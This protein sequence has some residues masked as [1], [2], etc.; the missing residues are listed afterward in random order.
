[1]LGTFGLDAWWPAVVALSTGTGLGFLY[2]L[3]PGIGGRIAI[4]LSLPLAALFDPYPAAIFLF[5]LHSVLNT[6]SSIPNIAFGVPTSAADAA[7]I[8]DGY[9]LTKIGRGGEAL[10]ASLSASAIG[11][12]LGALAFLVSIPIAR[13]LVTSFGPPEMLM[14][15]LIGVTLIASL[16]NEGLLQ[17]LVVAALGIIFAMVGLDRMTG[18]FR[19][20]F[21]FLDLW[22]GVSLPAVI[23]G[24]FVIPEMLSTKPQ[25][26]DVAFH[27]AMSTRITDVFRGM[28]VTF[29]YKAVL[30][31]STLYGILIGLTPAVG[32]TVAV[33][34]SYA[35]AARTTRSEIPFGQGAIAGVI[36]P[37]AANNSK[38][39]GAMI[40]TLFFAIPGSSGMAV[41]MAALVFVG[42]T[43]GPNM[44]TTDIGLSFSLAATVLLAN[45]LA[46]P[47]FFMVVPYIVRLSALR[48][49]AIVP[50]AIAISVTAAMI[51]SPT[52]AT[53]VEIFLSAILGVA[54]K[55]ANWPRPPFILG[56]V[57]AQMAERSFFL[58]A[59]LW[60]W[61]ALQR[62]LTLLL[63]ALIVGWLIF[64]L[65]KRPALTLAGS[66]TASIA[67]ATS[68]LIFFVTAFSLSASLSPKTGFA[69]A[70]V[71]ILAV[72]L[73]LIIVL[74][75]V[76]GVEPV[77]GQDK[78]RHVALCALFI[79]L[80]PL[81]GITA[82]TL[83]FVAAVL[84]R[85][86][87]KSR[88]AVTTALVVGVAQMGLLSSVF[89]VLVEKEIIGRALWSALDY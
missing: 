65:R 88:N 33:W 73:C 85:S 22:N 10:G 28:F 69:P 70:A 29:R 51:H 25:G 19:F 11:G 49:E 77:Q 8:L 39:G 34:M 38:E 24:M 57:I 36:A 63:L 40:P 54:L 37:E 59:E 26:D 6:S 5:A 31:R 79:L 71:S 58:T 61:S 87:L 74:A 30:L 60:G 48:R 16:S 20:T 3:V 42:V 4:I 27:R 75:A 7:T 81:I 35:Y 86:G 12:V 67:L 14:L 64:S 72:I 82:S 80:I 89:D 68:L 66:R 17:G 84:L 45:L 46:I 76:K 62:P 1:L 44:L 18:E 78:V 47:A 13:P 41:M 56:F 9:P 32:S 21:G 15:A 50:I 53:V 55:I 52:L 83:V 43:I 23:C 2:G